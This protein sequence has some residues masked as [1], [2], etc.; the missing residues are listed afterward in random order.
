[1]SFNARVRGLVA[2]AGSFDRSPVA[3]PQCS[4]AALGHVGYLDTSKTAVR[5]FTA[6]GIAELLAMDPLRNTHGHTLPGILGLK[7][8]LDATGRAGAAVQ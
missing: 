3:T 1:M 7:R 6:R 8:A 5:P 2:N 4:P